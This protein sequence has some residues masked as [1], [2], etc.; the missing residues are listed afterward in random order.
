MSS[1]INRMLFVCTAI[2]I[3]FAAF[4][5]NSA[6]YPRITEEAF[7]SCVPFF[8][9]DSTI[10][11]EARIVQEW[12]NKNSLRQKIVFR[13]AQG[14]LVPGLF[15]IPKQG[16]KPYPL[17]LLLHGWSGSKANWYE[18]NNFISGGIMRKALLE[19]GYA[20]LA[21]DA[22]THG[23]RSNEIDYLHVN[24]FEDPAAPLRSN[25]F[26]FAEICIQTVKDYQRA[27]DYI[28]G[29]DEID[30]NRIGLIGYS[31]GGMHSFFMLAA[32]PRLKM[33][34]ACVPPLLTL[35]GSTA[36]P[37]DYSR[38]I[39]DKP[40]LMLMGRKDELYEFAPMESSYH[41][42]IERPTTKI[43]WYD[44][45]HELGPIYVPDA[46]AWIKEYL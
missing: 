43:I 30:M 39:G 42:Y 37:V 14:F 11:L 23:E 32:E 18:D 27:L 24:P 5:E 29:R 10:P 19:S 21:L 28:A 7:K 38:G 1:A 26:S 12:D 15:E 31:M 20:V 3:A 6:P 13:G 33:A 36:S 4:A 16:E 45:G 46:L 17:V 35:G 22:A 25:Y 41:A 9:C 44:R 34:V 40:L 8:K 2:I